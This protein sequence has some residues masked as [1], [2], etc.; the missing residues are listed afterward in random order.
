[1]F[2][3]LLRSLNG[4]EPRPLEDLDQRRALAGLMVRIARSDGRYAPEEVA[5]IDRILARRYALD[6]AAA[7]A[8]RREGEDLER[9]APGT[10]RFTTAIKDS[11]PWEERIGVIEALWAVALADGERDAEEDSLLRMLANLLGVTDKDSA[12]A[13]QRVEAAP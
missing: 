3:N 4:P 13:R 6:P 12:L 7:E 11:V 9:E 2:S 10:H 1:M 8:L 5:R